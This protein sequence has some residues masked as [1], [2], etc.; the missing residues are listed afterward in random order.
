MT[1][2]RILTV[3]ALLALAVP[4]GAAAQ[5]LG[6]TAARQREKRA[7]QAQQKKP[8]ARVFTDA[9]LAVGRPP[10]AKGSGAT[11]SARPPRRLPRRPPA[12]EGSR[13]RSPTSWPMNSPTS[14]PSG[15]PRS[16][17]PRSRPASRS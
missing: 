4:A 13:P 15:R 6:D 14:R 10:E 9:D 8:E 1:A 3:F 16:S 17:W 2:R 7:K 12:A 11:A 5:G